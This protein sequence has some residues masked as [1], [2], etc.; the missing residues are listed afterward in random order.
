MYTYTQN[1]ILHHE[2]CPARSLC[3]WKRSETRLLFKKIWPNWL[4]TIK[5]MVLRVNNRSIRLTQ[6]CTQFKSP[7]VKII[8]VLY[9][10][11]NVAFS[12]KYMEIPETKK[13]LFPKGLNWVQ[14]FVSQ[15]GV[16]SLV[17]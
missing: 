6:C 1:R 14:H 8:C 17:L 7:G 11:Y 5:E 12:F 16:L 13:V 9:L 2:D 15:I 10:H 3:P 4:L